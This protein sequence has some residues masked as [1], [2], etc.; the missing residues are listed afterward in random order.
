MRNTR[1]AYRWF[2]FLVA[3]AS[4]FHILFAGPTIPGVILFFVSGGLWYWREQRKTRELDAPR[5]K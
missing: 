5:P 1:R 4:F 2:L 3:V